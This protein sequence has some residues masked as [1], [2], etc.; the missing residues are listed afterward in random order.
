MILNLTDLT[1]C[2][3]IPV[4]DMAE[5]IHVHSV[6]LLINLCYSNLFPDVFCHISLTY[7]QTFDNHPLMAKRVHM[8]ISEHNI[9]SLLP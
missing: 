2:F 5:C 9:E 7:F 6:K 4:I 8:Y 1:E 3:K